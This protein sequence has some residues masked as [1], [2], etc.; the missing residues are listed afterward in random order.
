MTNFIKPLAGAG[1][2]A[3]T[4]FNR[5]LSANTI[6]RNRGPLECVLAPSLFPAVHALG[7][8]STA[9]FR[10]NFCVLQNVWGFFK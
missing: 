6:A 7:Q 8:V 1:W 2:I 10:A 4:P 9:A 5:Q 3:L